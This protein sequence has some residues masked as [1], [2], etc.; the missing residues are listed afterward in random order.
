MRTTKPFLMANL[1][2]ILG[3]ILAGCAPAAA[4]PTDSAAKPTA[5]SPAKPTAPT[6]ITKAAAEQPRFGGILTAVAWE[7]PPTYD[8]HQESNFVAQGMLQSFYSGLVQYDPSEPEKIIPD[9]A[10]NWESGSDGKTLT[11]NVRTG[12]SFHDGKELTPADVKLSLDRL[13][14]PPKGVLSNRQPTLAPISDVEIF[15]NKVKLTLK[16]PSASLLSM[17]AVGQIVIFPKHVL[18]AK[19]NMKHDIVGTGPYKLKQH[20]LGSTFEAVKNTRYFVPD[21]PYLDGITLFIIRDAGTRLAAFRTGRVKLYGGAGPGPTVSQGEIINKEV[22]GASVIRFPGLT[23]R[24]LLFNSKEPPWNDVRV[25]RAASLAIDRRAAVKSLTQGSGEIGGY[26]VP[27]TQWA[28]APEELV[29]LPGYRERKDTD[30]AEAKMLLAEAGFPNGFKTKLLASATLSRD[31]AV[32][33][34]DQ[35]AKLNI[36]AEIEVVE[37]GVFATRMNRKQFILLAQPPG[38]RSA[39][40]VEIGR[41]FVS[42]CLSCGAL[43]D[44]NI[45]DLFGKADQTLDTNERRKIAH[46]LDRYLM[47]VVPSAIVYHGNESVAMAP[48]VRN[49]RPG[50]GWYNNNKYQDV[51]LAK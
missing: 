46:E 1:V 34:A 22:K 42:G 3:L 18:D 36:T 10:V 16:Y 21:R 29:K 28:T 23:Y 40:P 48:E 25:R 2:T 35:L 38:L 47:E 4:P 5:A 50:L 9:V 37:H 7:D 13:R 6:A 33:L 49:Y 15:E 24:A 30:I 12:V 51:W 26:F 27:G 43:E 31:L 20:N 32:F 45:D 14:D 41:Y 44:K 8:V 17:L 39:E 19:G 11:F